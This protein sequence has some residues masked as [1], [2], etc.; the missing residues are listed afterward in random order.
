MP[1]EGFAPYAARISKTFMFHR[2]FSNFSESFNKVPEII[3]DKN[4]QT[5][6]TFMINL[7]S[8]S[9]IEVQELP[10]LNTSTVNVESLN[11][12]TINVESL[13]TKF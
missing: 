10:T 5:M 1:N 6:T 13:F 12:S 8:N 4:N 7:E 9:S 11:T 2:L 3:E